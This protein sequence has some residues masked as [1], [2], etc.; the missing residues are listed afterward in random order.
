MSERALMSRYSWQFS[1]GWLL[2][3]LFPRQ[4]S[5]LERLP[6]ASIGWLQALLVYLPRL[7]GAVVLLAIGWLIA[8]ALSWSARKMIAIG[9]RVFG[10]ADEADSPKGASPKLLR[11]QQFIT[12]GIHALVFI[13]FFPAILA[14]SGADDTWASGF[15]EALLVFVPRLLTALILLGIAWLIA[16]IVRFAIRKIASLLGEQARSAL[17]G[18]TSQAVATD[19]T[20]A[21][22]EPVN[23]KP[24]LDDFVGDIDEPH[25]ADA[26]THRGKMSI[27]EIIANIIYWLVFLLSLPPI[28][29]ALGII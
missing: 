24:Q 15:L 1:F 7:I 13:L 27:S 14:A 16:T 25:S 12:I 20:A 19:I 26:T 23:T 29:S 28:L 22:S 10:G 8:F 2:A 4:S 18:E 11:S 17:Q 3:Y 21:N 5:F 9:F 6:S